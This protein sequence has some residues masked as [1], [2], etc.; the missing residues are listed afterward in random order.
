MAV[1]CRVYSNLSDEV[2][3]VLRNIKQYD[4]ETQKN[5]RSAVRDGTK[6]VLA[7]AIRRAPMRTG[8]LKASI[9]MSFDYDKS[10][11]IVRAKSPVAHLIEYG[12]RAVTIT[13][14]MRKAL[15]INGKFAAYANIP[16][17]AAH[18]FM[19]PAIEKVRPDIEKKIIEALK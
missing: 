8:K 16:A 2:F 10:M 18:P 3:K 13:P 14:Q 4:E 11:G 6:E 9:T 1:T 5:I 15:E 7:E 19:R 17:K 12:T